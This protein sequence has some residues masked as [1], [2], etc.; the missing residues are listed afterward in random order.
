MPIILGRVLLAIAHTKVDIFKKSV[1]LEVG[2]QK[3]V[4]KTKNNPNKTLVETVWAIRN[5]KSVTND[6]IM[7]IYHDLFLYNSESCIKTNKFNYLLAIDPDIF[8]Y[9]VEVHESHDKIN[10]GYSKLDQGKPW[11][12][13][14]NEEPNREHDIDLSSVIKLKE[15]WCKAVLQQKGDGHEFWA[16]CDPYNDQCN[17]GDLLDNTK[18]KC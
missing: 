12:I 11:E 4:F 8:S 16:S 5:E 6:N 7:K 2:Y 17:G 1:S 3:V 15:H 10:Y 9:E 13:E 14:A 18:E